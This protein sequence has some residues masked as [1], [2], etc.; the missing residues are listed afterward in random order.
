VTVNIGYDFEFLEH[1]V[2]TRTSAAGNSERQVMTIEP[3][4]I[5]MSAPWGDSYYAVFRDAPWFEIS[6]SAFLMEHVVPKLPPLRAINSGDWLI[7]LD[8]P[9]VKTRDQIASEVYEFLRGA[10]RHAPAFTF[11]R[12]SLWA[13]YGAFDHVS[14]AW[15]WGTMMQ[16][17]PDVPMFT[18]DLMQYA[19]DLGVSESA[20]P[21][22]NPATLHHAGHDSAHNL[23]VLDFLKDLDRRVN[24]S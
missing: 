8:H 11:P 22:Q 12:L 15:L 6:R 23:V 14:L 17:P 24:G 3:I 2:T 1:E 10:L 16:L 20:F 9:D 19:D 21:A 5:G 7:D 13:D 4:S 18:H